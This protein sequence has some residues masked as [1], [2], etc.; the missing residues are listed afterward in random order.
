MQFVTAMFTGRLGVGFYCAF[1]AVFAYVNKETLAFEGRKGAY[2]LCAA[3]HS[4]QERTQGELRQGQKE[5]VVGALYYIWWGL[6]PGERGMWEY[7]HSLSP[8]L[9]EYSS[10]DPNIAE[11]HIRWATEYGINL[12]EIS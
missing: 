1:L 11:Q 3:A 12:F 2:S 8:A 5:A 6:P 10:S 9:G 4:V 7:G